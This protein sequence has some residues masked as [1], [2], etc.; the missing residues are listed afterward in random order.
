MP[1]AQNEIDIILGYQCLQQL[2]AVQKNFLS[3]YFQE[4]NFQL[5]LEQIDT[6]FGDNDE[7]GYIVKYVEHFPDNFFQEV[8]DLNIYFALTNMPW[9]HSLKPIEKLIGECDATM[10]ENVMYLVRLYVE[11]VMPEILAPY[12]YQTFLYVYDWY[13][14]QA[15]SLILITFNENRR[16][17]LILEDLEEKG[18]SFDEFHRFMPFQKECLFYYSHTMNQF[19]KLLKRSN[20]DYMTT[21]GDQTFSKLMFTL[22]VDSIDFASI[23]LFLDKT[24][25]SLKDI[26]ALDYPKIFVLLTH[27]KCFI[28]LIEQSAFDENDLLEFELSTLIAITENPE[29]L[30]DVL[31]VRNLSFNRC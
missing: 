7:A 16:R 3:N 10:T 9:L 6:L 13:V 24:S 27:A 28:Q 26:F 15:K 1:L 29:D 11:M 5:R 17:V 25:L 12:N 4:N 23:L 14:I 22:A 18:L 8:F 2:T 31:N 19:M 30:S 21:L 20:L